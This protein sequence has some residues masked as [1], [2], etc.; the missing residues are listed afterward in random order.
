MALQRPAHLRIFRGDGYVDWRQKIPLEMSVSGRSSSLKVLWVS[1]FVRPNA[2]AERRA[3]D[4]AP[5]ELKYSNVSA[6]L[7]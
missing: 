6:I 5:S 2:L 1:E 4:G 3:T 7:L